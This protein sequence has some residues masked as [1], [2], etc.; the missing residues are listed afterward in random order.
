RAV[1]LHPY[2]G[3]DQREYVSLLTYHSVRKGDVQA[4]GKPLG[5]WQ[6]EL[7]KGFA[8]LLA[9]DCPLLSVDGVAR[10]RAR[11]LLVTAEAVLQEMVEQFLADRE[12]EEFVA[13]LRYILE[14]QPATQDVLHV[15]CSDEHVWLCD[16]S[17][18]L[19]RDP[20][21]SQV[22]CRVSDDADVH[23]EDLAMSILITHSPQHIVIHDLT[24]AA[25]WP[26]FAETVE[27]VFLERAERCPGCAVCAARQDARLPKGG[28][29]PPPLARPAP[30]E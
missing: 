16:E 18:V 20:E 4:A 24:L 10:F 17:G 6:Q 1:V 21:V 27:R 22:A 8:E 15:Y 2:L 12:Y 7:T 5:I 25:P 19:V 14:G 11:P 28:E 29:T 9:A 30:L 23:P 13:M 3:K 26:S